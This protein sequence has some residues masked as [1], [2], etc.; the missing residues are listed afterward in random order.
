MLDSDN[1]NT[2][3]DVDESGRRIE[4]II[5]LRSILRMPLNQ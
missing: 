2:F 4:R 3:V 5:T 1:E